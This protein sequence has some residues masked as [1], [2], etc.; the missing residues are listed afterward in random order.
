MRQT[1]HQCPSHEWG[2]RAINVYFVIAVVFECKR[3]S[4]AVP[5]VL[6]MYVYVTSNQV[7]HRRPAICRLEAIKVDLGFALRLSN[8]PISGILELQ[9][10]F[11]LQGAGEPKAR[12]Q[13]ILQSWFFH[14]RRE[15]LLPPVFLVPYHPQHSGTHAPTVSYPSRGRDNNR[16]FFLIPFLFL[17]ICCPSPPHPTL[18]GTTASVTFSHRSVSAVLCMS[19]CPTELVLP[20]VAQVKG[21]I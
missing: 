16:P 10:A 19:T 18:L 3:R 8:G 5:L 14:L 21:P 4:A 2:S 1:L 12:A 20:H 15:C 6:H 9:T 7:A 17:Y 11:A 13:A